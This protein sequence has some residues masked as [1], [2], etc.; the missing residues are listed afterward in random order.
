MPSSPHKRGARRHGKQ[1]ANG[2]GETNSS[3]LI[4]M[5]SSMFK[6]FQVAHLSHPS[7]NRSWGLN[8]VQLLWR[9]WGLNFW[10]TF[11]QKNM[12]LSQIRCIC[13]MCAWDLW[14]L[15]DIWDLSDSHHSWVAHPGAT[16]DTQ[17]VP[18]SATGLWLLHL[19]PARLTMC[20]QLRAV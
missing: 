16:G 13:D 17:A 5:K 9:V 14:D 3:N 15:W 7:D 6:T 19:Q 12:S 1:P 2:N 8:A 10:E 4:S 20:G 11:A 18:L